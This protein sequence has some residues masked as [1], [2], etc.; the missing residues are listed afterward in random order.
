MDMAAVNSTTPGGG[1][2]NCANRDPPDN[3]V[4]ARAAVVVAAVLV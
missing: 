1:L 4:S 2:E 3:Q